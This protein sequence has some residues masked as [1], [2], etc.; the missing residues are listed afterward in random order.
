MLRETRAE[1]LALI[2]ALLVVLLA[3]LFAWLRNVQAPAKPPPDAPVAT[4]PAAIADPGLEEGRR[5]FE[6]LNCMICHA[7]AGRGNP[8]RPLDGI[9][10]RKEP[11]AIRAWTIGTGAAREQLPAGT[12]AMKSR[13][14]GDPDLDALVNYLAHLK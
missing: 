11:S 6:R 14:A 2:T 12:I 5:A 10:A 9:G 7:I 8:A 4:A 3:A 13:A 1:L